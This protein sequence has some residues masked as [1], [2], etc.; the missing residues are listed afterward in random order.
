VTFAA[1]W[2]LV[3]ES[4]AGLVASVVLGVLLYGL[5]LYAVGR[6]RGTRNW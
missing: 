4:G 1:W 5:V 2:H 3:L 6:C